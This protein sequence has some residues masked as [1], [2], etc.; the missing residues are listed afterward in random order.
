MAEVLDRL[1]GEGAAD[2]RLALQPHREPLSGF[3]GSLRD[4]KRSITG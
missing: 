2:R 1:L 3:V 4:G